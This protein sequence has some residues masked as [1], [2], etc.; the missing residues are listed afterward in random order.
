MA[1]NTQVSHSIFLNSPFSGY[2][3]RGNQ[4]SLA[5]LCLNI[6][7]LVEF[8]LLGSVWGC[9]EKDHFIVWLWVVNLKFGWW[10]KKKGTISWDIYTVS[11]PLAA[12]VDIFIMPSHGVL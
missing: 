3:M 2:E 7:A 1:M 9:W 12:K 4:T 10:G 11:C 8:G 5:L 6:A